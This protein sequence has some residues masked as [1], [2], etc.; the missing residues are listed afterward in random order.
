MKV[1]IQKQSD[2]TSTP[3]RVQALGVTVSVHTRSEAERVKK[4]ITKVL[5][6]ASNDG[7]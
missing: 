1:S 7:A 4:F 3:Y 6:V 5:M 2:K